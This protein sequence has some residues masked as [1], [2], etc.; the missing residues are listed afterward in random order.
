MWG[1]KSTDSIV[2]LCAGKCTITCLPEYEMGISGFCV[3][4]DGLGD[5][6]A[7]T[8]LTHPNIIEIHV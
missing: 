7:E 8:N 2:F 3:E 5:L 1:V 6:D 4:K